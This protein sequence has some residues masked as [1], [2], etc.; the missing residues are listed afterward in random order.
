MK[1]DTVSPHKTMSFP[2]RPDRVAQLLL[3]IGRSPLKCGQYYV[4]TPKHSLPYLAQ[5]LL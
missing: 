2:A 5:F 1:Q 4:Y 3:S